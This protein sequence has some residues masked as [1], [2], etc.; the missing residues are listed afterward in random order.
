MTM[1]VIKKY[2]SLADKIV[3]KFMGQGIHGVSREDL[4]AAADAARATTATF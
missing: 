3:S 1:D 2:R 4:E